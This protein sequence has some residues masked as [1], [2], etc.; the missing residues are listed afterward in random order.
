VEWPQH[1]AHL[2]NPGAA[3]GGTADLAFALMNSA[4]SARFKI[5]Q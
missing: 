2:V 5:K 4:D 3:G 1:I